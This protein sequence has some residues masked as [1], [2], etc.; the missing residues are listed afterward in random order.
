MDVT[1][2]DDADALL[3]QW[4]GAGP[5]AYRPHVDFRVLGPVAAFVDGKPVGLGGPKQRTVLALLLLDAGRAVP[6][7]VLIDG[8]WGD[9]P[10]PAA[11]ST[12]Q[13]YVFNLRSAVGDRLVTERGG[14]RLAVD[15]DDVDAYRF[16]DSAVHAGR[17]LEESPIEAAELL[18]GGVGAVGGPPVLRCVPV[19]TAGDRGSSAGRVAP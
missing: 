7:D 2:R 16:E 1:P 8:V 11:K 10:T 19:P 12:L 3:K 6:A 14:Y 9:E 5:R 18:R 15:R 13:S 17:L 4:N